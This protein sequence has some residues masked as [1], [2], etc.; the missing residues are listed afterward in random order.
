MKRLVRECRER[1]VRFVFDPAHQLPMMDGADVTHGC[2]GAWVVIGNDYELELIQQ[3]TGRNE[4]GLLQLAELV[5]TT[6][7]REGSEIAT[8]DGVHR[9]PAAPPRTLRDPVGAGDAYRAGLV[10]ALL[11]GLDLPSAGRVASLA[12]T[13][14][15]EETGTVEHT[16]TRA[17]FGARYRDAFGSDLPPEM[18]G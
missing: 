7:G 3:R 6:L 16:Y 9:I 1:G 14:V 4:A 10:A 18:W 2:D 13:Y 17:E 11:R 15:V 8:R 5:V 12:A